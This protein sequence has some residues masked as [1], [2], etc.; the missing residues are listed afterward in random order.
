MNA[1]QPATIQRSLLLGVASALILYAILLTLSPA[2]RE[3]DWNVDYRLAHWAGMALLGAAGFFTWRQFQ[4]HT[5]QSDP[6]LLPFIILLGGLGML[7]IYR[8]LPSFGHRQAIWLALSLGVF[9]IGLRLNPRLDFLRRYKYLWLSG[10]LLLTALTLLLGTNPLGYGPQLWLGC[11]GVYLQPSE[12]LKLLLV[13]YLAAYFA[14][15]LPLKIGLPALLLPTVLLTGLALAILLVQRDLGTASIFIALYAVMLYLVIGR[16]RILLMSALGLLLAA[17]IGYLFI[18]I[19]QIRID[20]W[21]NPWQDPSGT[22]YQ[23]IQSLLALA[24]GGSIGR[25]AGMGSPGLVPVAISD[26]VYAAF[27]EETGLLGALGLIAVYGLILSRGI[28]AALNAPDLFRRY[29]AA[30]LTA[31]L[32]AQTILIIGGNIRLLPLTGVTL[33]FVSYGGSSVLTAHVA[34]LILALITSQPEDDPAPLFNPQPYH[35]L[36]LIL[37]GG[38]LAIALTTGWWSTVRNTDLLERTDNPRRT[39]ADRFVPRGALLDRNNAVITRS[40]GEPGSYRRIYLYPDLA[41]VTGYTHSVFGQSGLE[42]SLDGYLRGLQGNPVSLI[43]WEHLL[44]GQPPPGLTVRL[45][46]D[47][48]LQ[49]LADDFLRGERGAIVILNAASGEILAIS[50]QPTYDPNLLNEIGANLSRDANA[51][52]LNR[53]VQAAY[54]VGNTALRPLTL[55]MPNTSRAELMEKAGFTLAPA[56]GLPAAAPQITAQEARVSPL[57]MAIAISALSNAGV[58]PAPKLAIAVNTSQQGWVVLAESSQ[59]VIITTPQNA[60][61]AAQQLAVSGKPYWSASGSA[62]DEERRAAWFMGGTLPG[63][64]GAPLAVVVLLENTTIAATNEL[65][66]ALLEAVVE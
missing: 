12:P 41:T 59:P 30:G 39:I 16:K 46:I 49:A 66:L 17:A 36:S 61:Q 8:L 37:A 7:T 18:D 19:I 64:A 13:I 47:L 21:L 42:A 2:G 6:F 45:S 15:R 38:L 62:R 4:K 48:R 25:G 52:L 57:Q 50:S 33:P 51:P 28:R 23:I 22:G 14:D 24:N 9:A 5:P 34:A 3:R 26:F 60:E 1:S 55:A 44:Y 35:T 11:C 40:E 20:A 53:A 63:W 27:V 32:G 58:R 43:W 56:I 54:P 29:L 10:G 31:Y 65:G